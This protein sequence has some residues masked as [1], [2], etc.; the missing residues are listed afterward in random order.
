M[1]KIIVLLMIFMLT[2]C[3]GSMNPTGGHYVP[4]YPYFITHSPMTVKNIN[5]PTGTK[6]IYDEQRFRKGKQNQPLAEYR[7][8]EI[9][10]P[11]N[12]HILW[13]GV[14]IRSILKYFNSEMTGYTVY[15][16]FSKLTSQDAT[17][18]ARL[19]QSCDHR[20]GI[21]IKNPQDWSFNKANI[22]DINDCSVRYQRYFKNDLEQQQF[23]N[24][25]YAE[26]KKQNP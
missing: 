16:D 26:L 7:L 1:K 2:G 20:L 25:L 19:W 23:L 22:T 13:G 21:D 14:P 5:I 15:A 6:L 12:S 17:R 24:D 8:K 10:F 11:E 9:E 3:V 4:D 18:F